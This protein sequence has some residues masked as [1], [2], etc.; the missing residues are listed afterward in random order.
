MRRIKTKDT[1]RLLWKED[2]KAL[3]S[4]YEIAKRR[5]FGLNK[6]L[7]KNKEL[8]VKYD[9]IIKEHLREGIIERVDLNLDQNINTGYFLPHHAVVRERKNS[10]KVRIVFDASSKGK[11]ALSLNDCLESGP[12]LNTDLLEILLRFRLQKIAFSADI[13]RAFLEVGIAKEDRQ[14]L[15]FLWI[16]G[17]GPNLGFSPHN[18]ETFQYKRVTFGVKCSPFLLA[19]VIKLHLEKFE[20]K[21]EEACKMLNYLYV[22]D[23]ATGT[24]S[25]SEAIKLS[26]EM[27]YILSHES[28]KMGHELPNSK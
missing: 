22:D 27:I 28:S 25:V 15:K 24:A 4:N 20:S 19:A 21:Y 17:V 12:N 16:K 2:N 14:F 6:T 1:K 13:Q 23:L 8:F 10:T 7:D 18:I 9:G 11:G 3:I 26:K 5:L